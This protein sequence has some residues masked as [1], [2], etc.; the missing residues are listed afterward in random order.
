VAAAKEAEKK[1]A[2][3][4]RKEQAKQFEKQREA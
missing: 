1:K 2:L 4:L 3:N